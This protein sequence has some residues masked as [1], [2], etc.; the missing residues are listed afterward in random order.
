MSKK[1]SSAREKY[2]DVNKRVLIAIRT[3][4]E[5]IHNRIMAR[6]KPTMKFPVRS[7]SNVRYQPKRGF[8]EIA[9]QK[10]ERTLT[11][12]TVKTFAQTLRMVALSKELVENDDIATKREAYYVSKN[13]GDARFKEQ[14]ES[15]TVMD[16]IEAMMTEP[17]VAPAAVPET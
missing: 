13:W 10:K 15:D 12:N 11:V 2:P 3:S 6:K 5:N 16:D 7:L 4:A 8:F 1:S 17:E 14:S 9:G